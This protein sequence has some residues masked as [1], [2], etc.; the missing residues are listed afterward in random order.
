MLFLV[1][2]M[3]AIAVLFLFVVMMINIKVVQISEDLVTYLPL[4]FII[5]IIFFMEI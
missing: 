1:V 5:F 2:Y 3:G 4:G